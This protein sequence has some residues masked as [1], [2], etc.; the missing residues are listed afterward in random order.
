MSFF[1]N[2]TVEFALIR[3]STRHRKAIFKAVEANAI[4]ANVVGTA[5]A[6]TTS[7]GKEESEEEDYLPKVIIA[8]SIITNEDK[9]TYEKA[10]ADSEKF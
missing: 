3:R 9:S 4:T 8:K 10:M 1:K 7:A 2:I 5:K 6:P